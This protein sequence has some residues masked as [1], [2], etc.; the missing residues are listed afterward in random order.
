MGKRIEGSCK[1]CGYTGKMSEEHIPPQS[2]FN[3][4]QILF[5]TLRDALGI[6]G[7]KYS[8]SPNG[9][10]KYTL[11]KKC[12]NDTGDWYARALVEWT[13]QGYVWL[14]K[15]NDHSDLALPY[16]IYPLNV[17]KQVIVMVLAMSDE[18]ELPHHEELRRFILNR[19]QKYLPP[20]LHIYAYFNREGKARFTDQEGV[21]TRVDLG[22]TD[23][24]N[25]ELALPPFGYCITSRTKSKSKSLAEHQGLYEITWFS[26]FDYNHWTTVDLRLPVKQTH[27]PFPL[28]YRTKEE[29]SA[30]LLKNV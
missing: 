13:R 20:S 23:L 24:V 5:E 27:T 15:I 29:I 9:I 18:H 26:E 3:D 11:C 14:E 8:K 6:S 25:A 21:I 16:H 4:Q 17:I 12:N 28:D 2:A 22:T 30:D 1:I 10:K 7:R 19:G